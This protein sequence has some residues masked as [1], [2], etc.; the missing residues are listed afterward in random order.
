MKRSGN[1]IVAIECGTSIEF[2]H[3]NISAVLIDLGFQYIPGYK[4]R[5]NYQGLLYEVVARRLQTNRGLLELG[6]AD[7]DL[8][9]V[10]PKV[11]DIL[12]ILTDPPAPPEG[13]RIASEGGVHRPVF[14][15]NYLEREARN[16]ALGAA[17]EE[18]V[19]NFERARL[20]HAGKGGLADRIEH[21]SRLKGDGA[22]FDILSFENS[23][24]E[25]I[26]E[27][28]TTKYGRDTPFFVSRNEVAISEARS[29]QYHVYRLFMFRVAPQM[30][31]VDGALSKTC[32]LSATTFM[33]T[34][35]YGSAID[36]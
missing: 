31:V 5:S 28:K 14:S 32:R 33:A 8:S 9:I 2:K 22:G 6:A 3:A 7:A 18:F 20:I 17:G 11:D 35:E 16:Q 19:I 30:F 34:I 13:Q 12:S 24:A 36:E 27:V 23:G 4:P 15:V 10:A 26:I 29:M 1:T 21:T 25:R